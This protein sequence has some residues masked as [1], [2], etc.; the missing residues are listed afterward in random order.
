MHSQD[1][2]WRGGANFFAQTPLMVKNFAFQP[3]WSVGSKIFQ[4]CSTVE[5][6]SENLDGGY[7]PLSPTGYAPQFNYLSIFSSGRIEPEL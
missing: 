5:V 1:I 6:T 3:L 4:S 7:S 2:L